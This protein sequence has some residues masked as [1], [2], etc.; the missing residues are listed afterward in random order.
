MRES[1]FASKQI[2]KT[3]ANVSLTLCGVREPPPTS[4][5]EWSSSASPSAQTTKQ[6]FFDYGKRPRGLAAKGRLSFRSFSLLLC[7]SR[8]SH[9]L[10]HSYPSAHTHIYAHIYKLY[11]YMHGKL[12]SRKQLQH[13]GVANVS[14]ALSPKA[15]EKSFLLLLLHNDNPQTRMPAHH[16]AVID[17]VHAR[18]LK[19]E[20]ENE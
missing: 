12:V 15:E 4:L 20:R 17:R 3:K 6:C 10:S 5:W 8:K 2:S 13:D 19:E 1:S 16:V 7:H 11:T 18:D 9:S 14:F